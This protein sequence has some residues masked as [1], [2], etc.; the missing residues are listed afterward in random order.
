MVNGSPITGCPDVTTLPSGT[1]ATCT[2]AIPGT[3]NAGDSFVFRF[4]TAGCSKTS[5][6]ETT[7]IYGNLSDVNIVCPV[8]ENLTNRKKEDTP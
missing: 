4:T 8:N 6:R 7:V 5:F 2:Y 3:A 1:A